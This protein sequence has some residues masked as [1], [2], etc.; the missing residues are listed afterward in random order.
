MA[1]RPGQAARVTED[2]SKDASKS[3]K[4]QQRR[5]ELEMKAKL[6]KQMEVMEAQMKATME[7]QFAAKLQQMGMPMAGGQP[8]GGKGRA[9]AGGV[10]KRRSSDFQAGSASGMQGPAEPAH[11]AMDVSRDMTYEEKSQMSA[12][13]NKLRSEN[14]L[15]V[16]D[17]IRTN[18]PSLGKEGEEIQVDLNTLDRRTLWELHKFVH[19]CLN[20][21]KAKPKKAPTQTTASRTLAAQ[22]TLAGTEQRIAQ[23]QRSL[24]AHGA[25]S[26]GTAL[27][28]ARGADDFGHDDSLSGSDSEGELTSAAAP[29]GGAAGGAGYYAGFAQTK[30]QS[31]RER[32]DA[33]RRR[34]EAERSAAA[35]RGQREE[36]ER[37]RIERERAAARAAQAAGGSGIDM[38]GQSNAMA[39]FEDGTDTF[40]FSGLDEYG[41]S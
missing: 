41:E 16:V 24:A 3:L 12:G 23:L 40:D 31:D 20:K 11:P 35:K 4:Q 39:S 10:S 17:I 21:N 29:A 27:S 28:S 7:A 19:A 2:A 5:L 30:A 38:L 14:L 22:Q 26:S 8:T 18:M 33:E 9:K 37:A 1:A 13:I 36:Q 25:G 15:K 32:Q 6:D 34:Q